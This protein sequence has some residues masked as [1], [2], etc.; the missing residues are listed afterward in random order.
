MVVGAAAPAPEAKADQKTETTETVA[1][2]P[3]N[4]KQ[5]LERLFHRIFA[6]REGF[7]GWRQ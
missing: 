1:V 7:A 4:L 6:G 2:Q 5:R 3:A